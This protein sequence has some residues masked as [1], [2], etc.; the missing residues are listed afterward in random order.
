MV[1]NKLSDLGLDVQLLNVN[2]SLNCLS[3]G[4]R[5]INW[6]SLGVQKKHLTPSQFTQSPT[7]APH[8]FISHLNS[9]GLQNTKQFIQD[10]LIV[11]E[12][13]TSKN[14]SL[15]LPENSVVGPRASVFSPDKD[16]EAGDVC[17]IV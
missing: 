15:A 10:L 6:R 9:T 3:A 4:Q 2:G 1:F 13:S 7:A 8:R 5:T 17:F 14:I 16:G 12:A 11:H